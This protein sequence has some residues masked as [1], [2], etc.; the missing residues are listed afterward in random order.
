MSTFVGRR[1]TVGGGGGGG[2]DDDDD[3]DLA[4]KLDDDD[5]DEVDDGEH[6]K[7]PRRPVFGVDESAAIT[8]EFS[9]PPVDGAAVGGPQLFDDW[10]S[11]GFRL[12]S[13]R[14]P[15]EHSIRCFLSAEKWP[16]RFVNWTPLV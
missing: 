9:W 14:R 4:D 1:Q 6:D 8:F 13:R 10:P 11:G 3:V 16:V 15:L 2:G 7:A 5:D 12:A